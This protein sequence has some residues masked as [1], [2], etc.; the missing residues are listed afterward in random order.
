M[1]FFSKLTA[2]CQNNPTDRRPNRQINRGSDE[3]KSI[4]QYRTRKP[5]P[6]IQYTLFSV[7]NYRLVKTPASISAAGNWERKKL[8]TV[9]SFTVKEILIADEKP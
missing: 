7:F 3:S 5:L 4:S 1:F 8:A 2:I 6:G 9:N